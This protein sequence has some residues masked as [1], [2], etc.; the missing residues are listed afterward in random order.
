MYFQNRPL[1][2]A[3]FC[4]ENRFF[5]LCT[6]RI[7]LQENLILV[8]NIDLPPQYIVVV[9][10]STKNPPWG[11]RKKR[12]KVGISTVDFPGVNWYNIIDTL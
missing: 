9:E 5:P 12:R 7:W 6:G 2:A 10:K 3:G 11:V 4:C 8:L 1:L